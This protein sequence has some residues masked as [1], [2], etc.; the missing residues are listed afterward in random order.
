MGLAAGKTPDALRAE[1]KTV[2]WAD[3]DIEAVFGALA[4]TS[5]RTEPKSKTTSLISWKPIVIAIGAV[6]IVGAAAAGLLFF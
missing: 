1:L 4:A 2:G 6:V 5:V 3:A